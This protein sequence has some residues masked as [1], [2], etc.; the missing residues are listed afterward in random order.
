M[1]LVVNDLH[2]SERSPGERR[3]EYFRQIMNKLVE[4]E[5]L[6]RDCAA[7]VF[8]GDM[9]HQKIARNVSHRT[10]RVLIAVLKRFKVPIYAILGNHDIVGAAHASKERQ[11]IGVLLESGV[12]N[13]LD[14]VIIEDTELF[15]V[16]YNQPFEDGESK[17]N[18]PEKVTN[19]RIV[20]MHSMVGPGSPL[21]KN[22]AGPFDL[23]CYGHP[24]MEE[25]RTGPYVNFGSLARTT[26]DAYNRRLVKVLKVDEKLK[27][28]P[29]TL[30][31]QRPWQEIYNPQ[32][33]EKQNDE[34]EMFISVMEDAV[35]EE[36]EFD[37]SIFLTG[38]PLK[39]RNRV[40]HYLGSI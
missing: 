31:N 19:Q 32:V 24:H 28:W 30:E 38:L 12:I 39:V 8:T 22:I 25:G 35:H 5:E 13:L 40:Q 23:V 16:H 11:P 27:L 36:E 4:C 21:K 20:F 18:F 15:G 34:F 1:I 3:S 17:I 6:S 29:I 9:F 14:R 26:I 7:V 33:E 2:M 10:V 37:I